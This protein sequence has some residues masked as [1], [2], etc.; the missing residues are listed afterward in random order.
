MQRAASPQS[1]ATIRKAYAAVIHTLGFCVLINAFI[2]GRAL[3][4]EWE[5]DVHGYIGNAVFALAVA[6]VVLVFVARADRVAIGLTVALFVLVFAQIGLGYSGR[7][8]L[9]VR[10]WHIANGVL[11]F[12]VM[13]WAAA[14]ASMIGLRA[15]Q[16]R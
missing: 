2:A 3:I 5:I 16:P 8:N 11:L 6:A 4:G 7:E 15:D 9:D 14:R 10:P 1:S 12:G 13:T